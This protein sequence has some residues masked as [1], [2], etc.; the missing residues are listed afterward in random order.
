VTLVEFYVNCFE[1]AISK[2]KFLNVCTLLY[3][4][5]KNCTSTSMVSAL[6]KIDSVSN[7]DRNFL[8]IL[9]VSSHTVFAKALVGENL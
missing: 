8:L 1:I 2:Q 4:N 6:V 7:N 5:L 9:R 3:C